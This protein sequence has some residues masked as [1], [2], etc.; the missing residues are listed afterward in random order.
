[1]Y[2]LSRFVN[3]GTGFKG[4]D[5]AVFGAQRPVK[6]AERAILGAEVG[7]IDVAIDLV[8]DHARVVLRQAHLMRLHP[9]VD[10]VV[11]FEHLDR[12]LFGQAHGVTSI[13]AENVLKVGMS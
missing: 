13:L 3:I 9:D 4:Q 8:S 5:V 12:L 10:Q 7:V 2:I 11:G 6:G 1:V